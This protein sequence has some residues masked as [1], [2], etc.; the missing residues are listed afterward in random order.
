MRNAG[1]WQTLTHIYPWHGF[2]FE[3]IP[4]R[5]PRKAW[6]HLATTSSSS[7]SSS[8]IPSPVPTAGSGGGGGGG[9]GGGLRA[10]RKRPKPLRTVDIALD[11]CHSDAS[12]NAVSTTAV[13]P[14]ASAGSEDTDGGMAMPD[15]R[16]PF[17]SPVEPVLTLARFHR[18]LNKVYIPLDDE[19][20]LEVV[21][22]GRRGGFGM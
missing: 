8:C 19:E 3:S 12:S 22:A 17:I 18:S 9:G 15:T 21:R 10:I 11:S 16:F 5:S 14:P 13:A 7:S 2:T 6:L 20:E 1:P 4:E